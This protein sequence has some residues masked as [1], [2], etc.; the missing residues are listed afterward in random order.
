MEIKIGDI[1]RDR[2]ATPFDLRVVK[3]GRG[4]IIAKELTTLAALI[5]YKKHEYKY[6]TIQ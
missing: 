4:Y 5:K 2:D 1:V 6:L 3:V